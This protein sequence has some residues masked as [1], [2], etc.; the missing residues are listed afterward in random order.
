VRRS[1]NLI[2]ALLLGGLWHGANWTFIDWGAFNGVL[3]VIN[4]A[5]LQL[6]GPQSPTPIKRLACWCV[7]FIAFAIGMAMF[8]SANFEAMRHMLLAMAGLENGLESAN[9]IAVD[10]DQWLIYKGYI[11]KSLVHA[12]AGQ[13]WSAVA[14]LATILAL[15][16]ALFVPDT[17]EFLNYREGEPHA[18]WRRDL[19]GAAWQP[20]IVWLVFIFV[21]FGVSFTNF[22]RFN[23]F[24]YYRF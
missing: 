2:A 7:T 22:W 17:M 20:S 9:H 15:G 8:R 10:A 23:K 24:L 5:W 18:K 1:F 12:L 16:I 11:S 6:R 3:L 21:L 4:H 13:N 14:T 19:R